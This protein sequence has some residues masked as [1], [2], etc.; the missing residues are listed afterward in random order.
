MTKRGQIRWKLTVKQSIPSQVCENSLAM[1]KIAWLRQKSWNCQ[2][3]P[4]YSAE[5]LDSQMW[6]NTM[7]NDTNITFNLDYLLVILL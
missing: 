6:T 7:L 3:I 1:A 2:T 5:D 4:S